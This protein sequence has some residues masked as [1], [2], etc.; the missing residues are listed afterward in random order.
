MAKG[1]GLKEGQDTEPLRPVI[2]PSPV[3]GP[4]AR[5]IP[6]GRKLPERGAGAMPGTI[7]GNQKLRVTREIVAILRNT[8]SRRRSGRR[9][10]FTA[11]GGEGGRTG[12]SDGC[13]GG[14]ARDVSDRKEGEMAEAERQKGRK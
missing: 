2:K 12:E 8:G 7:C 3:S 4:S 10:R 11:V 1:L 14:R 6:Q 13:A 9:R 5:R